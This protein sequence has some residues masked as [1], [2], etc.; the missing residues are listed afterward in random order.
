MSQYKNKKTV[1]IFLSRIQENV[2]LSRVKD[3]GF[4]RTVFSRNSIAVDAGPVV[5][6]AF[7]HRSSKGVSKA[8]I[9]TFSSHEDIKVSIIFGVFG[10]FW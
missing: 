6:A 9:A 5:S 7:A 1:Y 4:L 10:K 2:Y 8:F 3:F